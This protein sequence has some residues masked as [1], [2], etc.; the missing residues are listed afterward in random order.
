MLVYYLTSFQR[1]TQVDR[2][3]P[4]PIS[5]VG[6]CQVILNSRQDILKSGQVILKSVQVILNS[7]HVILKLGQIMSKLAEKSIST[8]RLSLNSLE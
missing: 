6:N 8:L 2:D 4:I 3:I 5:Q 7:N 1:K